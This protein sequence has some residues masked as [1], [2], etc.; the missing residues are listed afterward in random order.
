MSEPR[1][2]W[3]KVDITL[4]AISGIAIPLSVF[5]IGHQ[6][7]IQQEQAATS[8][9]QVELVNS[10]LGPI[11]SE[12]ARQRELA[13]KVAGYLAAKN[14][15]PLE[16][17][18]AMISLAQTDPESKTAQAASDA[19]AQVETSSPQLR[20]NIDQA[21]RSG[22]A[23]IYVHIRDADQRSS[24]SKLSSNVTSALGGD[25][26]VPGIQQV[27]GPRTSELRYFHKAEK[28][29]AEKIRNEFE[30]FNIKLKLQD[31]SPDYEDSTKI[32]PRH[33][34]LWLGTDFKQPDA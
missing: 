6:H 13:I 10:L 23:R 11:T 21:F 5:W 18:P 8:K 4:K 14:E 3:S 32:R 19:L 12:N 30:K 7:S 34:E 25:F 31:L 33:Y 24:A 27:V 28:E 1:D 26:I 22:P 16:L 20:K 29:E 17:V 2:F 15:L 9:R